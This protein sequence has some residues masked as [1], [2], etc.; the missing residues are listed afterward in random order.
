VTQNEGKKYPYVY[1]F[2]TFGSK[3]NKFEGKKS[4]K[5]NIPKT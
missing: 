1:I 5:K 3:I 4:E 2:S